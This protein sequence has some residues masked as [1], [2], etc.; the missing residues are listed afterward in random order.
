MHGLHAYRLFV[1]PPN[2]K[3]LDP[4]CLVPTS[5]HLQQPAF[6]SLKP[7]LVQTTTTT[8][9]NWLSLPPELRN[10]ILE[11]LLDHKE[12]AP[13]AT[14]SKEWRAVIEKR[15]LSHLKLH[16]TCLDFLAQLAEEQTA[17]IDHIWLNIELKRYTCRACGSDESGTWSRLNEIGRAHV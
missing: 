14:V 2:L 7:K 16:P 1:L 8:T 10:M 11:R 5:S 4:P 6:L 9:M 13:Y 3:T 12:I 15:K 17:Q